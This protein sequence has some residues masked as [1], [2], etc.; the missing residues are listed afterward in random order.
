MLWVYACSSSCLL[1]ESLDLLVA[2]VKDLLQVSLVLT[3]CWHKDAASGALAVGSG[4][5]GSLA[6]DKGV[7]DTGFLAKN[8]HMA[9]NVDRVDISSQDHNTTKDTNI[10]KT[11]IHR[12][13]LPFG[14]F[15]DGLD[16]LLHSSLDLLLL[17][18]LG[19]KLVQALQQLSRN[20]RRGDGG[21][22]IFKDVAHGDIFIGRHL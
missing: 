21:D 17:G 9:E 20:Q 14:S 7:R 1:V 19:D 15:T 3:W 4:T 10:R 18:S 22:R 12:I 11:A 6:R 2:F 13:G 16:S 5:E 8:R